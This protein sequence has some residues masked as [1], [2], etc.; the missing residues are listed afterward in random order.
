MPKEKIIIFDTTLRDG[1]QSPGAS[2]SITEKLE[3]A[4]QLAVL[5]VDVIEA[6]FPVSS[7]AQFEA[8]KVIAEEVS[9]PTI[10]GL[11]RAHENDIQA[12]GNAI[13]AAKKKRIHTF[14]A[15]S[16]IHMEHK[17]KKKPDEVLKMA[18]EA[19]KYA[20]TFTDD[21]EFSPE[22]AC[23]SEMPFL[24]EICAAAIEAGATTLNIPDTVGYVLPYEYGQIIAQLKAD[25][26]G[27]DNCII[28]THCHND[29]GMAV[30]NSLAGVRNGAR[31]VECTVNGLG[32]RAG[33]AALEE[34]VMAIH[35][36]SGFFT[37]KDAKAPI[38]NIST[39]EIYRTSQLVSR[40][41][42]FVIQPNKAVVGANAFAHEA[43]VHVDGILKKKSTYEI[44]TPESIGL[45]GSRMV[46]GR[47]TGRHGF[48]D[49]C[50]Q[51]GFKLTNDE[52]EHAYERFLQ[53]ADKK[54]EVFDED[55]AVIINDEIHVV[56]EKIYELQ[57]LHVACGTGT[58]PTASVKIKTKDKVKQ[59]AA[60]GDGPVDAAYE[61]IREATGRSPELESYSIKAVTGGKEALGEATVRISEEGRAAI[62]RGISTDIIEA[63]AKAYVD[64]INRMLSAKKKGE[65]PELKVQL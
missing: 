15:T 43:G 63:S 41:T 9:G 34:I 12:A 14:I 17:L 51:L 40:L 28:S 36:R 31:Q 3:I 30:A 1:E 50:K 60:C 29:L 7:P 19:I 13:A 22:D 58:L 25:V 47:H 42:G 5:G 2:L 6:G 26:P 65:E 37:G 4:H 16:S 45:G 48:A 56:V 20:K 35:T 53:I 23:R 10:A 18:V 52:T 24:I 61:A 33:N 27:I 62:G 59:A 38:L 55:I 39:K 64:A 54:K 8:T 49:R 57:Y 21:V 11:A 44:M 46:L 32:E